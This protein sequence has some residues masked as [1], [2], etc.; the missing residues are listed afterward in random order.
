MAPRRLLADVRALVLLG[1][2]LAPALAGCLEDE[3]EGPR[4]AQPTS[5][6]AGPSVP[7]APSNPVVKLNYSDPGYVM[8]TPWKVGDGWDW[9]SNHSRF[10]TMRVLESRNVSGHAH[11]LIEETAGKVGNPANARSRSWVNATSWAK[12]NTTDV[13]GWL[14]VYAPGVPL[15]AHRNGTYNY[16][17]TRFDDQGRKVDNFSSYATVVYVN[18]DVVIR[19]PWSQV[20]TGKL[21]HRIIT[22]DKDRK[23]A[24]VQVTHWVSREYAN[25]ISFQIN[26]DERFTLSAARVDGRTF[27]ELRAT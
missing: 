26:L 8:T 24:R 9:E 6:P 3:P 7:T 19:L 20:A 25:D 23:E 16:T 1:L 11:F 12:V 17:E 10:R 21:D 14:S 27:R 18:H 4:L 15:R 13:L 22:L 2:L 5:V